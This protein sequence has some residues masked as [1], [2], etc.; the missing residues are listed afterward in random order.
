MFVNAHIRE[1]KQLI[2]I[3]NKHKYLL[4]SILRFNEYII[5]IASSFI[6]YKQLNPIPKANWLEF[7]SMSTIRYVWVY[8]CTLQVVIRGK[9][10]LYIEDKC[11]VRTGYTPPD[12]CNISIEYNLQCIINDYFTH[13]V[14]PSKYVWKKTVCCSMEGMHGSRPWL[15]LF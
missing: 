13:Q 4:L 14:I 9:Y 10:L 7:N 2:P 12:I 3:F 15:W 8:A 11:F 1:I 5:H 6:F